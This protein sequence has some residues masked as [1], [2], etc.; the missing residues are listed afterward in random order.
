MLVSLID[1]EINFKQLVLIEGPKLYQINMSSEYLDPKI[2]KIIEDQDNLSGIFIQSLNE[3]DR[4]F[5]TTKQTNYIIEKIKDKEIKIKGGEYFPED[6]E[7]F[8]EGSTWGTSLIKLGWI[9]Y[10]ML[11]EI[12]T[13]NGKILSTSPVKSATIVTNDWTYTMDWPKEDS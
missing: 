10:N 4:I 1:W 6:T 3:G 9:G 7:V 12:R 2:N 8:L 11:M 5:V 13:K